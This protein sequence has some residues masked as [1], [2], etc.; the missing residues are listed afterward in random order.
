MK[1]LSRRTVLR[2]VVGGMGVSIAL[3][4]LEAMTDRTKRARGDGSAFPKRFGMWFFGNGVLPE[5][6][7][8]AQEGAG[9]QPSPLLMPLAAMREHLTLVT[10]TRVATLN[11]VPHGSGPAGLL[12]GDSLAGNEFNNGSSFR[13]ATIDQRIAAS[14][15]GET[16][17]RSIETAVQTAQYSLAHVAA[18]QRVPCEADPRALF[19]RLFGDG[20]R[21]PGEMT[22]PDPR[23]GLRRSVLDAVSSQSRALSS[24]VSAEDRRRLDQHYTSLRALESQLARLESNP[25][26]LASCRRPDAP[27]ETIADLM[28]RPDM[29]LRSRLMSELKAMALGCD[30]TRVFFHMYSQPVNNTLFQGAPAGHHQLTHDELGDQPQVAAIIRIILEDFAG[31][32]QALSRIPEGDETLLDHTM[33]LCTTD[34]SYG[35]THSLDEYPLIFAGGR[36]HGL[37]RG[38]HLRARGENIC[39]VSLSIL[40]LMGLRASEF[41]V[42]PGRVT[43]PLSGLSV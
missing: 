4:W 28:G 8:P 33:V 17:F 35:R 36:S 13:G 30:I 26:N 43:E 25:P 38:T 40:Q 1:T 34:C 14:I 12:T 39:K 2:G 18:N 3:P 41:G 10:G 32:L 37:R 6:W 11:T 20:F 19:N 23:L 21:A 27:P 24:R 9:W 16:R 15:G 31:F 22:M 5:Q 42:G 7:L 29:R